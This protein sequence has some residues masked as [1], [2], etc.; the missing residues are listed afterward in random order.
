MVLCHSRY[1]YYLGLSTILLVRINQKYHP[2]FVFEIVHLLVYYP[3]EY[4]VD[5]YQPHY[6]DAVLQS[7]I[8]HLLHKYRLVPINTSQQLFCVFLPMS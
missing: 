2:V 6:I 3:N 5:N 7:E 4:V 8:H 1:G